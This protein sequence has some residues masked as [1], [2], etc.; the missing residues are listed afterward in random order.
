[1]NQYSNSQ[2]IAE[3]KQNDSLN[4]EDNDTLFELVKA[5]DTAARE[6][7]ITG[8]MYLVVDKVDCF[9]R[10]HPHATHLRDDLTSAGFIGLLQAVNA[11]SGGNVAKTNITGYLAV[12]IGREM[13]ELMD[14]ENVI[15]ISAG[16]RRYA[17]EH[18][19]ELEIPKVQTLPSDKDKHYDPN[20]DG[21]LADNETLPVGSDFGYYPFGATEVRDLLDA[22][23]QTHEERE[24]MWLREAGYT[25]KEISGKLKMPV[26]SVHAIKTRLYQRFLRKS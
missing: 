19:Y 18:G 8:N 24:F 21:Q 22:C 5:G 20:D 26:A 14:Q 1:M 10:R 13:S 15:F 7:M 6:R 25:F 2:L 4:R 23:C 11:I 3:M 16:Q 12:G 17:R 9:L